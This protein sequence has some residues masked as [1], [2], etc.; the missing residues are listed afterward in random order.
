MNKSITHYLFILCQFLILLKKF[1]YNLLI[2]FCEKKLKS[3][4]KIN[5][6]E[7][8]RKLQAI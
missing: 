3:I 4:S 7:K 6:I 1:L 8:K 5:L 2:F